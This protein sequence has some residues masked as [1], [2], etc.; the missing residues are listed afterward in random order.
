MTLFSTFG[1]FVTLS[2]L[3]ALIFALIAIMP[4]LRAPRLQ[5]KPID[6]Q[7]L[8]INVAVF[9]ERLAELQTDKDSGTI[10]NSHY[11]NQKLELERQLLDVQRQITPMVTPDVKSRLIVAAWIPILAAMA[12]LLIGNRTPV[13]DL[14]TAEDKVGQVADD[15]LTAKIDKPPSWAFEDGRQLISAMQTNVHRNADDPNRWMRLSELFLSMEATDSALEALSRA[16]RL[17]PEN[18]EIATTYAQ[19]SFFANKGQLDANI[20]RVLQAIL[21]KNPQHERAQML[22]AMGET[23]SSN[24]AQAQGWIKRLQGSIVAKPGDH[25]KALASLDEL[26][27]YV[28]TQ[29]KQ[30]LEGIDVTVKINANLLPLVKADD[31]LFVAIRDVKGGPPFAAKRLP[32]S[33]IKQ[34]EASIRLSNLDAMMPDRTL[35]SARSDKTQLAVVARISHSGNAIAESGDL[36]GNP[37]VISAEQTQVNVEINQQIP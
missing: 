23:R 13:F 25:T 6:N 15:L 36:S 30:A 14:W 9:R 32:I 8:D 35:N 29:E 37:I 26:S 28:S 24:F 10:N 17:A 5:S 3:I 16:Y 22:M 1:L 12:Y 7:L 27:N 19:T 4:W 31:V 33:I 34:G 21:A 2:L 11:Q 18:E 20:R